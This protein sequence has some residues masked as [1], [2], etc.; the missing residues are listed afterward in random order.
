[1]SV[2]GKKLPDTER[3]RTFGFVVLRGFF[4]PA[5]LAAEMDRV[6]G[7]GLA[8]AV[9]PSAGGAIRFRYVPMMTAETP[10]SMALLDR[11]EGVAREPLGGAVLPTRAKGVRYS[12]DTP[13]HVDS[14]SPVASVGFA[15][16]LEPLG[17]HDLAATQE[18]FARSRR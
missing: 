4:E 8:G 5:P 10:V 9:D 11:L 3:L 13:W 7:D 1:M 6:L 15:A 2:T 17:I 12:G 16:Y 18:A 14:T